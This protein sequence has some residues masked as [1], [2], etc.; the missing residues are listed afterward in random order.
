MLLAFVSSALPPSGDKQFRIREMM[1]ACG[2]AG[3]EDT[4][5]K[6]YGEILAIFKKN[7][8]TCKQMVSDKRYQF[9]FILEYLA[10]EEVIREGR[11]GAN[12][13][14]KRSH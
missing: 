13:A 4:H 9:P 14:A 8:E 10:D 7:A 3:S 1:R 2:I 12:I 6:A 11:E 5:Q